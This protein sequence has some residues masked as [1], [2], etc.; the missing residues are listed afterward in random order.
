MAGVGIKVP[1]KKARSA[2]QIK[3]GA[4]VTGPVWTGCENWSGPD[5]HLFQRNAKSFYYD[6]Y[7]SADL[8]PDVWAWMKENGYTADQIKAAKAAKGAGSVSVNTAILCK[9]LRT[10]MMDFNPKQAKYWNELPGTSGEMKPVTDHI[11]ANL[12]RTI[13][14]GKIELAQAKAE[15][16][17]TANVYVP[18]I[19]ERIAEQARGAAEEIDV[20]L[21]GFIENKKDFDP[22]GFDFKRHFT[23][24]GVTQA[25]ARKL[26][27]FYEGELA[28]FKELQ[29][30]PTA[31]QMKK[32]SEQDLD[33]LAQLKEGYSHLSK[34]DIANYVAALESLVDACMFVVDTSKAVRK[35][36]KAK[37]KSVDKLI[38][39]LNYLKVDTTLNLA[40]INPTDIIG[41]NELWVYNTK[42]RKIGKYVASN[43]DPKGMKRDG[44]GLSIKGTTIIGYDEAQSTMK[45]L[46]K[47]AEQLK[48]FKAA[49]K[50]ALRKFMDDIKTTEARL[51]GRINGETILLKVN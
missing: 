49:G 6:N 26:V 19:Q 40:S 3:R 39:K 5:Y 30:P 17:A 46:R 14:A 4:K 31:A 28:E 27:K 8:E 50:V 47:P 48:E 9:M 2:P 16:K 1:K 29:N 35:P 42:S 38:A 22:K 21:D 20:W 25:H 51:N 10:G 15:E 23:K 33:M 43:I 13:E 45:T 36:R 41:A 34:K 12:E 37:P 44:T 11:K 7:K 18:T 32:M 24:M